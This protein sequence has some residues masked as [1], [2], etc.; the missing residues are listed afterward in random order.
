MN[1]FDKARVD[2]AK[3]SLRRR[4]LLAAAAALTLATSCGGGPTAKSLDG[5]LTNYYDNA[6]SGANL[7]ESALTPGSVGAGGFGK[8]YCLPVDDEIYGQILYVAD[9]AGGSGETRDLALVTTVNNSVYAFDARS[10]SATPLWMVNLTGANA[11]P[12]PT[13]DLGLSDDCSDGYHDFSHIVGI[14]ST[15]AIDPIGQ[16]IFLVARTKE[17]GQYVQRL[18]ALDLN[19]G[20]ER[21]NSPAVL[22]P[23]APG[24]APDAVGGV[25]SFDPRIH[26]QRMALTYQDGLV[27]VGWA[28]H[29]DEGPFHGWF[30]GYDHESLLPVVTYNTTPDGQSGGLW[31]SGRGPAV[32]DGGDIYLV[33]GNGTSDVDG[34]ADHSDSFIR[35]RRSGHMLNVVDWFT[36]Y[37]YNFLDS[38]DLDL[39]SAGALILPGHDLVIGGGKTGKLYAIRQ[40]AFG[41]F[42]GNDDRQI[43]QSLAI[44]P[45]MAPIH[46]SPVR[47][48]SGGVDYVYVMGDQD[49]LHQIRVTGD[50]LED[51][52]QSQV[53]APTVADLGDYTEPGGML[54]VSANGDQTGSGIIWVTTTV[55]DDASHMSVAGVL[56]AFDADDVS[57]ELWNSLADVARDDVG[58]FAKYNPPT[59]YRGRVYVPTFSQQLCVYGLL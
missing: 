15:P 26:N 55:S 38:Q 8:L 19:T 53:A 9:L 12:V 33:S 16:T 44:T 30:V 56:R 37:N 32:D 13:G 50:L 18:H 27:Y 52:I 45:D 29:C 49:H 43:V 34:S 47:W 7:H 46:G 39:G 17:D 48:N 24:S 31:Q 1:T 35:L 40:S 20:M 54:A 3:T 22:S 23:S 36:P 59:V 51:Y 57:H 2:C 21:R 4:A 14:V 58:L 25:I 5:V 28:A 42:N 11:T 6:R 41:V 10:P